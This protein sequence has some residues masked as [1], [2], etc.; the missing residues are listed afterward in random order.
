[1][2]R[3]RLTSF[4]LVGLLVAV[5]AGGLVRLFMLRFETGDNYAAYS[6]LRSDP[7]GTRAFYDSLD[8]LGGLVVER[9]E[10]NPDK[11]PEGAGAT[12][13]VLGLNGR[14]LHDVDEDDAENLE[15]FMV[16]GGRL[17]LSLTPEGGRPWWLN[18]DDR[19]TS[20]SRTL[21]PPAKAKEVGREKEAA[22]RTPRNPIRDNLTTET[23]PGISLSLRWKMGLDFVPLERGDR[24]HFEPAEVRRAASLALPEALHW[25]SGLVFARL[26]PAW[27][28]IYARAGKPVLIER[29]WGRGTLVMATDSFMV[30]NEAL[31]QECQPALLAW[32]V[33]PVRRVVF[34]ETHLGVIE[35]PGVMSLAIKYRLHGVI[36]VLLLLAAL[37]IWKSALP[38]V[39]YRS[40]GDES[41]RLRKGENA[42]DAWTGLVDLLRRNIPRQRILRVCLEE[43]T[44]TSGRE[45]REARGINEKLQAALYEEED[46]PAGQRQPVETYRTMTRLVDRRARA[47]PPGH[48]L[49][50]K[51]KQESKHE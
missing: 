5:L 46:R 16:G 6:T 17:V 37:Y 11:F 34:D 30:S 45:R 47:V 48:D 21:A 29:A 35:N 23:L 8:A 40:D 15:T 36:A 3:S 26:G 38:L 41:A 22:R 10:H 39:P 51:T 20:T 1:L 42:R 12:L 18:K 2:F 19:P 28:V 14:A 31:R 27:R 13:M 33:G 25:R 44:R 50:L 32:L 9:H 43:W 4:L 7:L 49:N 24:H